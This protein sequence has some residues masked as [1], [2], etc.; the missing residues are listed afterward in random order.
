[1]NMFSLKNIKR[2][3]IIANFNPKGSYPQFG[4]I[5]PTIKKTDAPVV[6]ASVKVLK[7]G[8]IKVNKAK[9]AWKKMTPKTF[10]PFKKTLRVIEC[11]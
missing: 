1:M 3:G 5:I 7:G 8:N 4:S 9:S 11:K 10:V 6:I 2:V